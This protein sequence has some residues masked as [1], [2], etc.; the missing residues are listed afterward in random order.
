MWYLLTTWEVFADDICS[1]CGPGH[2]GVNQNIIL[3][4]Q[5]RQSLASQLSLLTT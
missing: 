4:S 5:R 1:L 3:K 2:A